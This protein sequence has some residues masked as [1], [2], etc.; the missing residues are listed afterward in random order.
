MPTD[1]IVGGGV[2]GDS[3]SALSQFN[4]VVAFHQ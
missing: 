1:A 3:T 4:F 2:G